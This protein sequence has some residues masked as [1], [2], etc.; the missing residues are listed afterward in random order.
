MFKKS[1][2]ILSSVL[3]LAAC[4][5]AQPRI[6]QATAGMP[7]I[8]VTVGM[9]TQIEMPDSG[10]VQSI[11]IGDPSLV[12]AEQATDVVSIIAK[13]SSGETNLIIRSRD[14]DGDINVYQYRVIVQ[15]R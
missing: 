2:L 1:V 10:R 6:I 12:S 13:G 7:D 9:A 15:A 11:A 14:E 5:S 3:A 8:R 4:S